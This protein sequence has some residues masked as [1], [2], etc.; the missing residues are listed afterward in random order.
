M[1]ELEACKEWIEKHFDAIPTQLIE[2]AYENCI[3]EIDILAPQDEDTPIFPA[4]G[5]VFHPS[6]QCD[7]EWIRENAERIAKECRVI[8]YETD[9]VG[10]F[11]GI[12]GAGYDFYESHW[13]PLYRLRHNE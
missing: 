11:I 5:W 8:I 9:E 12:D 10:V 3:D 7:E 13:L 2:K 6:W 4:W 1:N